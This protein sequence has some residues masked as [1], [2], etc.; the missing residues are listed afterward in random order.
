MKSTGIVRKI[1]NLGRMVIPKELRTVMN[2]KESDPVEIF[3]DGDTV[4]LKKFQVSCCICDETENLIDVNGKKMC[5]N[6]I[7]NI[8]AL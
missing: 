8:K 1:D 7:S 5:A 6:C 3:M 2:L 4:I